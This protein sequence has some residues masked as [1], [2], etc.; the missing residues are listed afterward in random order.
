M[1]IFAFTGWSRWQPSHNGHPGGISNSGHS[2]GY[3]RRVFAPALNAQAKAARA[4][5]S[6]AFGLSMASSGADQ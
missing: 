5:G 1:V 2:A 4:Q 3:L 6:M